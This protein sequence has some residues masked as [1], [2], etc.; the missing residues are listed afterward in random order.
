MLDV[1]S[2]H[3]DSTVKRSR[4]VILVKNLPHTTTE[5]EL[6]DT[7]GRHGAIGMLTQ[8]DSGCVRCMRMCVHVRGNHSGEEFAA[9][10]LRAGAM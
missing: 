7:F 1:L 8:A 9:H 6:R 10:H 2:Q 3:Q 4:T 5:Q